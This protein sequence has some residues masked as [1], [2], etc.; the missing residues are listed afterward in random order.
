MEFLHNEKEEHRLKQQELQEGRNARSTKKHE[1]ISA[2]D[3]IAEVKKV[4]GK[5]R[6]E[7]W[8][9]VAE[10]VEAFVPEAKKSKQ[11]SLWDSQSQSQS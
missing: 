6:Q 2:Q 8:A 7:T 10:T 1:L 11:I 3:A 5:R 9:S 4:A